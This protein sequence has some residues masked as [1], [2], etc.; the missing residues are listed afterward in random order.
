MTAI[1]LDQRDDGNLSELAKLSKLYELPDFVKRASIT[2]IM[3]DD[4]APA[5]CFADF[6]A[7]K[8]YPIHTKAATFVSTLYF[9][10]KG[11]AFP[12]TVRKLVGERLRKAA[13]FWGIS[14]EVAKAVDR[15]RE[16]DKQAEYPDSSYAL[17]VVADGSKERR[18]PLRNSLEV[19]AAADWFVQ[20]LPQLRQEFGFEDRATIA[21]NILRKAAELG[22]NVGDALETL[23]KAAGRGV[24]SP[25]KIA[26]M[27]HD[28]TVLASCPQPVKQSLCKLAESTRKTPKIFLD[29]ASLQK[30]ASLLDQFDRANGIIPKYGSSAV[31][32]PEDVIFE[33]TFAKLA[34]LKNDACTTTTGSVYDKSQFAKLSAGDVKDAFGDEIVDEVCRDLEVDPEKFAAVASTFPRPDA[35]LLDELMSTKGLCPVLKQ[36]AANAIGF[37]WSQYQAMAG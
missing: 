25:E 12:P 23:E 27:L 31:P 29:P 1:I 33:A 30:L 36:A 14:G 32:A 10:E 20:F 7:R 18:Y 5:N 15:Q 16:L 35:Q 3:P 6:R 22:A 28:R 21:G 19:K 2:D 26:Q 8:H 17:V 11:A 13:A 24:G 9:L 4:A 34:E 37:D